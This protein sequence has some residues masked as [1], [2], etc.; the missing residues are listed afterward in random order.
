MPRPGRVLRLLLTVGWLAAWS[1]PSFH[2]HAQQQDLPPLVYV[3]PMHSD[4]VSHEKGECPLCRMTMEPMRLD[5][6]FTCPVHSV[7]AEEEAGKCPIC[8]RT[9][10]EVTVKVAWRCGSV[11]TDLTEP[12]RC[13]DGTQAI[14]VHLAA[15]HGNHNPQHGGQFFMAQDY[16]H[17]I[18]GTYPSPGVFRLYLYDDYTKPLSAEKTKAIS[19]RLVTKEETDPRTFVTKEVGSVPL[20]VAE[21]GAYLEASIETLPLPANITLQATFTPGGKEQRF[22]FAFAEHSADSAPA[23]LDVA[24][25]LMMEIP[26]APGEILKMLLERRDELRAV[27]ARGG[28]SEVWVPGLQGK[29]LALALEFHARELPSQ[30]QQAVAVA[31]REIVQAAFR[32]DWSGDR[33]E[34]DEVLKAAEQFEQGVSGLEA[35]F[36][37]KR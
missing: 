15:A 34:R 29:E 11:D 10:G 28:L 33:G 19:A 35:A 14:R 5:Q 26:D 21:G 20:A 4:Q 7:I 13:K 18:E 32:L 9:L 6:V 37:V 22:D 30:R 8:G 25:R 1:A 16:W 23:A 17:H 12:Q 3:C 31:T 36:G 27:V 24:T 2:A